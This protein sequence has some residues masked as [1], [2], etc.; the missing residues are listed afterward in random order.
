MVAASI[1]GQHRAETMCTSA[2]RWCC[3]A[4]PCLVVAWKGTV[5]PYFADGMVRWLAVFF[6]Q[7]D[8]AVACNQRKKLLG[9][10]YVGAFKSLIAEWS[11]IACLA[12]CM[13]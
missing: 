8:C 2:S 7:A 3:L 12:A 4:L 9:N 11:S 6:A 10:C 13:Q 5:W 1:L